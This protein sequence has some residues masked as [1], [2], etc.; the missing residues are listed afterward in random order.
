MRLH[1]GLPVENALDELEE[2]L[3]SHPAAVLCAD[4]G[5]GK[6]TVVPPSLLDAPFLDGGKILMLEPR[7]I[8]AVGA[9]KRIAFLLGEKVGQTAGY[10][11]RF[12]SETSPSTRIEVITEGILTRMIQ[13]D[14]ELPGVK[15]LIFDEFHERSLQG[16]SASPSLWMCAKRSA[17]TSKYSSCPPPSTLNAFRV[18]SETLPS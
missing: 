8:A 11:T 4:P 9:A 1:T 3:R 2:A 17:T 6:S 14:P 5:A 12:G 18:S 16:T 10:R 15:L 13:K 7:R